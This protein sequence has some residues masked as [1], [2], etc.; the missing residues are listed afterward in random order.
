MG[1]QLMLEHLEMVHAECSRG[2]HSPNADWHD[3]ADLNY[4]VPGCVPI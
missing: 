2:D 4:S 1:Q 3:V